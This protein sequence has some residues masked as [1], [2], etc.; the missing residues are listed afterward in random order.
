MKPLSSEP[1]KGI[2]DF[3]YH[4]AKKHQNWSNTHSIQQMALLR[5]HKPFLGIA[6][7]LSPSFSPLPHPQW[8][9]RS[10][11]TLKTS[12]DSFTGITEAQE[13]A[14]RIRTSESPISPCAVGQ[15]AGS[16]QA[17]RIHSLPDI[18]RESVLFA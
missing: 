5:I 13:G 2:S 3:I 10:E 4:A 15:A 1:T 14:G 18:S 8:K 17:V 7:G 9:R 12:L 16:K 6:S 11:P